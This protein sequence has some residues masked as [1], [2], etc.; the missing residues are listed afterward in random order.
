ML[1]SFQ[2]ETEDKCRPAQHVDW[3]DGIRMARSILA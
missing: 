3:A 1:F 2:Q